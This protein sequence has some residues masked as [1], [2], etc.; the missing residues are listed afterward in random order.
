VGDAFQ[1]VK[2]GDKLRMPA[3]AYNAFIDAAKDFQNRQ[4]NTDGSAQPGAEPSSTVVLVK[5]DSGAGLERYAVLG[6]SGPIYT[7]DDNLD[8]FKNKLAFIG[9]VPTTAGY[10]GKFAVLLEPAANGT[11]VRAVVAGVVPVKVD[12][13]DAAHGFA[14]VKNLDSTSLKSNAAGSAQILWK[15]SGTGVKWALVRL[16]NIMAGNLANPATLGGNTEGLETPASNTWTR[17]GTTAGSNYAGVPLDLWVV[18]RVVYN[19]A[20]DKRIYKYLRKLSFDTL[21]NLRA[22][23][24]ESRVEVDAPELCS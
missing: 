7:P 4:R 2:A 13:G 20:G 10:T 16:N 18:C 22:V 9:A 1:K 3:A 14:D 24:V 12:F 21:G 23:N 5:N 15:Q 19:D 6:I 17:D 8:S 11:I